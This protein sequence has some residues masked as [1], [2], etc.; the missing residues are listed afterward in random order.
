M[1]NIKRIA[2]AVLLASGGLLVSSTAQS[3]IVAASD[4]SAWDANQTNCFTKGWQEPGRVS[5]TGCQGTGLWD[6]PVPI[7]TTGNKTFSV[8]GKSSVVGITC[9][10]FVL[11]P[12]GAIVRW[13]EIALGFFPNWYPF[14]SQAVN[15]DETA[16]VECEIT[17]SG[18]SW[19][20]AVKGF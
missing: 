9:G 2:S 13:K 1:S 12:S 15:T 18:T 20:G 14:E 16:V 11:G 17:S 19:M 4:G 6:V 7:V 10:A 8:Y 3:G 5:F